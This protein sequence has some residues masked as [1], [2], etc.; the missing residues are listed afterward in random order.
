M[1]IFEDQLLAIKTK[2]DVCASTG[3]DEIVWNNEVSYLQSGL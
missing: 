1:K 3:I 2:E